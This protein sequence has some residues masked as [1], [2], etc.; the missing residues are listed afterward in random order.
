MKTTSPATITRL[1]AMPQLTVATRAIAQIVAMQGG[2]TF[3]TSMFSTVK[4][5]FDVAV[6]RLVSVP[7]ER[8]AKKLCACPVRWRKRSRR[9]SPVTPTNVELP[10]QLATRH[11]R[12]SAAMRLTRKANASH[13]PAGLGT[14][15]E[16]VSTRTFTPY[17]VMTEHK[18]ASA[19]ED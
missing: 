17:W 5:A 2:S 14:G 11:K 6:M 1:A 13:A 15:C 19:T 8:L 10:T 4:S 16:R 7:G 3:H 12:L 9:T 18:T